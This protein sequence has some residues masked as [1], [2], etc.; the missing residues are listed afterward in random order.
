MPF[1]SIIVGLVNHAGNDNQES[2]YGASCFAR[3]CVSQNKKLLVDGNYMMKCLDT[4]RVYYLRL[5]DIIL[6]I[7]YNHTSSRHFGA[8]RE[9]RRLLRISNTGMCL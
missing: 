1:F 8:Q 3:G 9:L 2:K 7:C 6:D 4:F 5:C